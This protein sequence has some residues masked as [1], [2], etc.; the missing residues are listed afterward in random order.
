LSADRDRDF[1]TLQIIKYLKKVSQDMLPA[2]TF[3]LTIFSLIIFAA[4]LGF[5]ESSFAAPVENWQTIFPDTRKVVKLFGSEGP[6]WRLFST[7]GAYSIPAEIPGDVLSDLLRE[8][9][10]ENPYHDRNFYTQRYVW[11]G[12]DATN[13]SNSKFEQRTRTWVY[14]TDFSLPNTNF[15]NDIYLIV[16]GIKMGASIFLDDYF[17]GNIT[18]QFLRYTF[19]LNNF[20][21][22]FQSS[23]LFTARKLRTY[24]LTISFPPDLIT[25]GR[26]QACSGGWDWAPYTRT[27]DA[28]G[29]RTFTFGIWKPIYIIEQSQLSIYHVVPKI[30]YLGDGLKD[31]PRNPMLE[32]PHHDFKVLV[33]IHFVRSRVVNGFFL[34]RGNFTRKTK[35]IKIDGSSNMI[36]VPFL[37]PK[38]TIKLWWPN[39]RHRDTQLS[40]LY[41]LKVSYATIGTNIFQTDWVTKSIGFRTIDLI[42]IN[43]TNSSSFKS[44]DQE[45][46]GNHGMFFRVNGA[47]IWA[48]GAN[49]VPM[50]QLEGRLTD[51]AHRIMVQ[52]AAD[53]GMNML[54]V[55]GGG[56]PMPTSFYD[57]C[58]RLGILV[59]H[60]MLLVEENN[61]GARKSP[62]LK[63][64]IIH[65]V[66]SLSSHPCI[67]L[68]SGC[69]EC[70]VEMDS[71][72]AIYATFV[73]ETV[74]REDPT[75]PIWPSCPSSTGWKTGVY[76][77]NGKPNGNPLKTYNSNELIPSH[78]IEKHGPYRHGISKAYPSVNS[79]N[80]DG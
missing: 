13:A 12:L 59:Y 28:Y 68:W 73:M 48:K 1:T 15:N 63:E 54:R 35:A 74:A 6:S 44:R 71:E 26:F 24:K 7:D 58:D 2:K 34:I 23:K 5:S 57:A 21:H 29:S 53:S 43:E 8:G 79:N 56:M 14:E 51:E 38:E 36:S 50:D 64:E 30:F 20:L 3:E 11:M 75:R 10:I 67:A 61:H 27:G 16:E 60:D 78:A 41:E 72:T 69:N 33:D 80:D 49:V 31:I 47:L 76:R 65:L 9:I 40:N 18:D 55:W 62:I 42:T 39:S 25:Y 45:G 4:C 66:Q 32:G 19:Q 22:V 37:V 52:S 17:L 70:I 77:I 46:S